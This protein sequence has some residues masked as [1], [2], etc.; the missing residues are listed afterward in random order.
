MNF[1]F[2]QSMLRCLCNVVIVYIISQTLKWDFSN[3]DKVKR[4]LS[5]PTCT[6]IVAAIFTYMSNLCIFLR[7]PSFQLWCFDLL[8]QRSLFQHQICLALKKVL[9]LSLSLS[10]VKRF[11]RHCRVHNVHVCI[12]M[13]T[14]QLHFIVSLQHCLN[15]GPCIQPLVN[16][17]GMG[18]PATIFSVFK[19]TN[20]QV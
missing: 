17:T 9:I 13:L 6:C 4:I 10:V 16:L 12:S 15:W 19:L 1:A 7:L 14:R 18:I 8:N 20:Y 5:L 11:L 3:I 2:L